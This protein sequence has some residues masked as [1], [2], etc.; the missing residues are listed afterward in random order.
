MKSIATR[1]LILT[2]CLLGLAGCSPKNTFVQPPPPEVTVALPDQRDVTVYSEV[3]G[4]AE[5]RDT[6]EIRARVSGY[7]RSVDFVDGQIVREGDRLFL[8]EPEPYEAAVKAGEANLSSA[9]AARDIAQT[10]YDRRVQAFET[11]AVSE[12]DVLTA[13]AN[14]DSAEAAMLGAEAD[15]TR[16]R[17][18]LSYTENFAPATGRI[19][20]RLVSEGN[21]VGG[22]QATLLATLVV[23]DPIYVYFNL[24]ERVLVPALEKLALIDRTDLRNAPPVDLE[25]ADGSRY[26]ESGRI[27][28][29]DNRA[30]AAT[31]TVAIRAVFPNPH[32]A[33]L[34][35][36][37]GKV[38]I[39]ETVE[40]AL[41]VPDLSI[42]RD[43]GGSYVLVVDHQGTVEARYVE[44]GPKVGYDRVIK[45]GLNGDE[46]VVVNG[47]QRARPGITVSATTRAPDRVEN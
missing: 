7:L 24:S 35:G 6:I 3:P 39:P 14:L 8:I 10:N 45:S 36:L 15:L 13:K 18:N 12:I 40:D 26:G 19:G 11:K 21:L 34:P 31:G 25:L 9:I 28:Y 23:Q 37:Y 42:Q 29:V 16:A 5:A 38:L 17:I 27:D 43:I 32:G 41:L 44:L 4:R 47:L 2:T 30:D 33:L 22:G 46:R 1:P 20:R